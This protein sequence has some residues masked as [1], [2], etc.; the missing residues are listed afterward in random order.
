MAKTLY[1]MNSGIY[2]DG[3]ALPGMDQGVA[4][5]WSIRPKS[6]PDCLIGVVSLQ[7]H[8]QE[9]RGFWLDPAWQ[10]QGLM[11]EASTAATDFWFEDLG[12]EVLRV[13]KAAD[14][15]A[16]RRISEA[17]GMRV[18]AR[19]TKNLVSGPCVAELWEITREDWRAF[20]AGPAPV[21]PA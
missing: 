8:E 2:L 6:R 10:G 5:H 20:R 11:L 7:D 13:P 16:S 21:P 4:W 14:N 3:I 17:Q 9:N 1:L 12:R 19:F 18:V 15:L